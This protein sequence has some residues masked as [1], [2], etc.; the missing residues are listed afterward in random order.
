MRVPSTLHPLLGQVA[1]AA[2][3]AATASAVP[4]PV[5]DHFE[6]PHVHPVE[7]SPD[8]TKLFV[9]HT[10]DHKLS[11]FDLTGSAPVLVGQVPVG[12]EPVS[13]TWTAYHYWIFRYER[14]S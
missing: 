13:E 8:G 4:L 14:V 11:V 10:A 7:I 6:S 5:A 9:V 12:L 3:F 1:I 2:L